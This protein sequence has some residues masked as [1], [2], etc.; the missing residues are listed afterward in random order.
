[1]QSLPFYC[2]TVGSGTFLLG[3]ACYLG[4]SLLFGFLSMNEFPAVRLSQLGGWEK[5]GRGAECQPPLD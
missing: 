2:L 1:M 5:E 4:P 3:I